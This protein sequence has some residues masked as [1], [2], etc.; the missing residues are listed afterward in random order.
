MKVR[1]VRASEH[2]WEGG[3]RM[4]NPD[5]P[6]IAGLVR[7]AAAGDRR[8][9]ER[10]VEQYARLIWSITAEFKLATAMRPMSP[11]PRG[12]ACSS[13]STGS[14]TRIASAPGW[15]RRRGTNACAAW[16]RASG[17]S[18]P[19]T[20]RSSTGVVASGPEVD[21]RILA[22][23]RDQV[24]RDALVPPAA[25]G[26]SGCSS[27]SWPIRPRLTPTFPTS[28]DLPVGQHRADPGTVPGPAPRATA[29]IMSRAS[30]R[31][32]TGHRR[33]RLPG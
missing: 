31:P 18:W 29:G 7:G 23:E 15:R 21:E 12:S 22:D 6:D 17:S 28:L 24:V 14:S 2:G 4:H 9:W 33:P 3:R 16:R 8:A 1:S 5:T 10:L 19:R 13:T 27:C 30:R 20:T 11:R 32:P 26:G 25:A